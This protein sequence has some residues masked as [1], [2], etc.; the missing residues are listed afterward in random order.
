MAI[1]IHAGMHSGLTRPRIKEVIFSSNV[2]GDSYL[3]GQS[4]ASGGGGSKVGGNYEIP[5]RMPVE[6]VVMDGMVFGDVIVLI[7]M[8]ECKGMLSNGEV[9]AV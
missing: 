6:F 3:L 5:R 4:Y 7:V 1:L 9:D 2:G 8:V